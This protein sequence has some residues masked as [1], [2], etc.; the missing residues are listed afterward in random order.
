MTYF[1]F[2]CRVSVV[3]APSPFGGIAAC[4]FILMGE[5]K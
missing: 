4:P 3:T 5:I 1:L 2:M